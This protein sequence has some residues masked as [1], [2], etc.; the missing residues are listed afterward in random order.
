MSTTTYEIS[1][2]RDLQFALKGVAPGTQVDW[3]DAVGD[4]WPTDQLVIELTWAGKPENAHFIRIGPG[5]L[6]E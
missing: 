4:L 1:T 2:V 6:R 5:G 3:A